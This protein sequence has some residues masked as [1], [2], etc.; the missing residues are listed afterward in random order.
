MFARIILEILRPKPMAT[1]GEL[2]GGSADSEPA[3]PD[4]GLQVLY[5]NGEQIPL[6]TI[7]ITQRL[8]LA[9]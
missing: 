9:S 7:G 3:P 6:R 8:A 5:I 4:T 1:H 2:M